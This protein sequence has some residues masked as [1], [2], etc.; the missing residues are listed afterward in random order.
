MKSGFGF[1]LL[2]T[3][4][5]LFLSTNTEAWEPARLRASGIGYAPTHLTGTPRGRLMAERAA[6]V[7]AMRN[8]ARGLYAIPPNTSFTAHVPGVKTVW[9]RTRPGYGMEA[10]IETSLPMW[11]VRYRTMEW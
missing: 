5:T 7:V 4:F 1:V 11:W 3:T 6:K 8:L 9:T 2:A 10:I